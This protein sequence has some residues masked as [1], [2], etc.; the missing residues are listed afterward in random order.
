MSVS[1]NGSLCGHNALSIF[2]GLFKGSNSTSKWVGWPAKSDFLMSH[3]DCR[4]QIRSGQVRKT[5]A[6]SDR[7]VP[8]LNLEHLTQASKVHEPLY[9]AFPLLDKMIAYFGGRLVAKK[10]PPQAKHKADGTVSYGSGTELFL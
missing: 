4:T 3:S 10:N 8:I 6:H 7:K 1:H 9:F 2:R 5:L